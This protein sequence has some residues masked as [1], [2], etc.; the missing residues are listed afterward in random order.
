LIDTYI[1][2]D[3]SQI[4]AVADIDA[5]TLFND[6]FINKCVE[7]NDGFVETDVTQPHQWHLWQTPEGLVYECYKAF[8]S[9]DLT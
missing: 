4:A 1:D 5:P 2:K 9:Q 7:K 6:D 8:I 3:L